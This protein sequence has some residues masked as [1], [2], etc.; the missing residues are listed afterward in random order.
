MGAEPKNP[1]IREDGLTESGQLNGTARARVDRDTTIHRAEAKGIRKH[2]MEVALAISTFLEH[3][4]DKGGIVTFTPGR[5]AWPSLSEQRNNHRGPGSRHDEERTK[6]YHAVKDLIERRTDGRA[7][8]AEPLAAFGESIETL[9]YRPFRLWWAQLVSQLR[10][11]DPETTPVAVL[12]L[13]AALVEGALTFVAKRGRS[14]DLGV[15]GSSTFKEEPHK[16]GIND[17]INGAAAG[18]ANAILTNSDRHRADGLELQAQG[19]LW[20]LPAGRPAWLTYDRSQPD[21][22]M[23]RRCDGSIDAP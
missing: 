8:Y 14:L 7:P 13:A 3:L 18:G 20:L 5:A 15:F 6:A 21:D 16:W 10:R 19:Q 1:R 4:V 12:I 17:L 22:A 2:D 11:S 23:A 9:G